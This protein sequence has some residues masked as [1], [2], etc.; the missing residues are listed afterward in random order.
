MWFHILLCRIICMH[1]LTK[2]RIITVAILAQGTLRSDAA[3]QASLR[4]VGN[5]QHISASFCAANASTT[6]ERSK[7]AFASSVYGWA[8]AWR[9]GQMLGSEPGVVG[10][11]PRGCF[12]RHARKGNTHTHTHTRSAR[13]QN[14]IGGWCRH[15]ASDAWTHVLHV[16]RAD[17]RCR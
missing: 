12:F 13:T 9:N 17:A 15:C 7:L 8:L 3:T 16:L 10:S 6:H 1:V 4:I 2:L 14:V 5:I 11:I